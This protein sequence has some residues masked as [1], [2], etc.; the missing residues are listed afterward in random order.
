MSEENRPTKDDGNNGDARGTKCPYC[1][2]EVV[3]GAHRCHHCLIDIKDR[4]PDHDGICP[5]CKESIDPDASR[6]KWCKSW[7]VRPGFF[8]FWDDGLNSAN[9]GDTEFTE[10]PPMQSRARPTDPL[11][12]EP[13]WQGSELPP[14]KPPD[15]IWQCWYVDNWSTHDFRSKSL[16]VYEECRDLN[17]GG[18]RRRPSHAR[19]VAQREH[20]KWM[21][22]NT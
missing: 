1:L 3:L 10:L 19:R 9:R 22:D 13:W 7:I 11:F 17:N 18:T 14:P 21:A 4:I 16:W 12:T 2:S 6:C 15:P 8:R 20:N 5:L